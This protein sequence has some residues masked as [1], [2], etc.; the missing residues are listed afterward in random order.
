MIFKQQFTYE[1]RQRE[2]TRITTRYPD[3]VPIIVERKESS[4]NK[5]SGDKVP[6]IDKHKF[7]VPR[8]LTVGQFIYV[9]RK[10][11]KLGPEQALF[12]FIGQSNTI[13]PTNMLL[14]TIYNNHMDP[15]LFLYIYYCGENTFG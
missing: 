2:G 4:Y 13:P 14:G 10:R 8:D 9:I 5:I 6:D 1:D 7:L 3:R 11:I 12:L 15:D